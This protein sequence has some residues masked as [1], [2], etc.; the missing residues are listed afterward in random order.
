LA[1]KITYFRSDFEPP[2][3]VVQSKIMILGNNNY[4]LLCW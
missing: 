1:L 4:V 3:L 2:L